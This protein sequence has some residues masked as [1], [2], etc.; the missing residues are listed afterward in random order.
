MKIRIYE[1]TQRK[2]S[3]SRGSMRFTSA[4]FAFAVGFLFINPAPLTHVRNVKKQLFP[5]QDPLSRLWFG[6]HWCVAR[7]A[8]LSL[9]PEHDW[10]EHRS[11]HL[12]ITF[13]LQWHKLKTPVPSPMPLSLPFTLFLFAFSWIFCS[14]EGLALAYFATFHAFQAETTLNPQHLTTSPTHVLLIPVMR[15][16]ISPLRPAFGPFNNTEITPT[17]Q[18]LQWKFAPLKILIWLEKGNLTEKYSQLL[19]FA[20]AVLC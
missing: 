7:V 18:S 15:I 9:L 14:T 19:I 16:L 4:C 11:H 12:F 2:Y 8:R 20:I 1:T 17:K 6:S 5:S 3:D 10:E 13:A